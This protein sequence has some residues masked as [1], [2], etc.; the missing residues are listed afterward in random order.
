MN[1]AG[2]QQVALLDWYWAMPLVTRLYFTACS[3]CTVAC[4][5]D[6]ITPFHLYY[7][8]H[9]IWQGG[10]LWRLVTNFFFFGSWGV[11]FLFHMY[12]LIRYCRSLEEGRAFHVYVAGCE[13]G[14][15]EGSPAGD[16]QGIA[17]ACGADGGE[18][19]RYEGVV[20]KRSCAGYIQGIA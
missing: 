2:Q 20:A 12:F 4:A 15:A 19:A 7:N 17:E 11:D 18:G 6:V 10:Q 13:E 9:A 1:G 16:I 14:V 8:P 5:L 3:L